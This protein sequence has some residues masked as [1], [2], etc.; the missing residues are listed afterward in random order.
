MKA[1]VAR[2][3]GGI[4]LLSAVLAVPLLY[5]S[6][7]EKDFRNFRIVEDGVLYRSGQ[8]TL[9]GLQ[10]IIHDY[11]IRTII[12]LRAGYSL[13]ELPPDRAEE[14]WCLE[15]GLKYVRIPP[16]H[17]YSVD[18]GPV[19]AEQGV[20]VFFEVMDD[21]ANHPVLI[22]CF[23]GIHRTGNHCALYRM[24]YNGW[25]LHQAI[26]EMRSYGYKSLEDEKDIYNYLTTYRVRRQRPTGD[27]LALPQTQFR[28]GDWLAL[29]QT[30]VRQ[31]PA[32]P[33]R[34][35]LR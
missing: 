23:A 27:W 31:R 32:T 9:Q 12:S 30:Q 24:E 29:P 14:A 13:G 11:Q 26:H 20:K 35:A 15:Q 10:R 8:L 21:A 1:K 22:H 7:R 33:M 6:Q 4:V 2:W 16:R 17:W 34:A 18:G 25:T 3:M 28:H 19:P 5:R